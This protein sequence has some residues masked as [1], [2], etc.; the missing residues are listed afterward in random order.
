MTGAVANPSGL[1]PDIH[2]AGRCARVIA[3]IVVWKRLMQ[4]NQIV[5]VKNG[6]NLFDPC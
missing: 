4:E 2:F 5:T 1:F 3:K 6:R